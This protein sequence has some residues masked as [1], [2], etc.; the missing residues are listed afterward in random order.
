MRPG[1][2]RV[3]AELEVL[4]HGE[5]RKDLAALGDVHDAALDHPVARQAIDALAFEAHLA[6][7]RAQEPRDRAQHRRLAGAVGAHHRQRLA[8]LDDE[9]DAGQRRQVAVGHVH[10]GQL[11][12]AHV[13]APR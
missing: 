3:G 11:E 10:A 5:A 7:A 12:L 8:P 9:I 1:G 6:P 2:P 4:A 13:R